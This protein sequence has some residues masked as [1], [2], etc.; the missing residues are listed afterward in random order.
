MR[1]RSFRPVKV[2]WL[3]LHQPVNAALRNHTVL[4][5]RCK[6]EFTGNRS[7][8]LLQK[9]EG[10]RVTALGDAL[11]SPLCLFTETHPD[12]WKSAASLQQRL[13]SCVLEGD[14]CRGEWPSQ[15][16]HGGLISWWQKYWGGYSLLVSSLFSFSRVVCIWHWNVEV[17]QVWLDQKTLVH[18]KRSLRPFSTSHSLQRHSQSICSNP[19]QNLNI[20]WLHFDVERKEISQ[21]VDICDKEKEDLV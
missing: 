12:W 7:K 16:G 5:E 2:W 17:R 21:L 14:G 11:S 9:A 20:W 4:P 19:Q 6:R 10:V 18:W 15:R 3:W 13:R 8:V 1:T